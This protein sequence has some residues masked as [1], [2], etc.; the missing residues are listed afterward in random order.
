[1]E[2]AEPVGRAHTA[3][4]WAVLICSTVIVVVLRLTPGDGVSALDILAVIFA[5]G[6]VAGYA[7]FAWV[8]RADLPVTADQ[9]GDNA[10]YIGLVLTFASLG[11]ALFK[12]VYVIDF[13]SPGVVAAGQAKRIAH[14]IPDFG[15]ALASTVAGIIARLALQQQRQS[16]AEASEQVR[17]DLDVAA[18]DFARKLRVATGEISAATTTVRLGISK[19]LEDAVQSQVE[20]FE[21]AQEK[22]RTAADTMAGQVGE[23]AGRMADASGKM[24]NEFGRICDAQPSIS[25][26]KLADSANSSRDA[27][28]T[29]GHAAEDASTQISAVVD[30]LA[31]LAKRL[32]GLVPEEDATQVRELAAKAANVTQ[33]VIEQM[34]QSESEVRKTNTAIGHALEGAVEAERRAARL[35]QS[36]SRVEEVLDS[37]RLAIEGDGDKKGIARGVAERADS[38]KRAMVGV[39]DTLGEA[40]DGI[41]RRVVAIGDDG[42]ALRHALSSARD[43]IATASGDLSHN[44]NAV[45]AELETG[46][47]A[48]ADGMARL[49][50][51]TERLQRGVSRAQQVAEESARRIGNLTA[52]GNSVDSLRIA[53]ETT[54][55]KVDALAGELDQVE[56]RAHSAVVKLERAGTQAEEIAQKFADV[57]PNP[58]RW[59]WP[60]RE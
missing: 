37:A 35:I 2:G 31:T 24:V 28:A 59:F 45:A 47:E 42:E 58:T 18:R 53:A 40:T 51:N 57:T 20:E 12:L 21:R 16:P 14:L 34:E 15:V 50:A 11:A 43:V 6:A 25:V 3:I 22:V 38:L 1:M 33:S 56:D 60:R 27:L 30:N 17:R 29:M 49:H 10:Y 46:K 36:A 54:R 44:A 13:E 4:L 9:A 55:S 32:E 41:D 26:E 7:I 19:Q 52:S 8:K 23:L 39:Q 5:V 48:L